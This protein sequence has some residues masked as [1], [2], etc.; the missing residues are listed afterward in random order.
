LRLLVIKTLI[1]A[2]VRGVRLG[3]GLLFAL[4]VDGQEV[5]GD[6]QELAVDDRL[7]IVA[8]RPLHELSQGVEAAHDVVKVIVVQFELI[9]VKQLDDA[10][11][12]VV[13][14]SRIELMKDVV[15]QIQVMP[16]AE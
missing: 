15:L 14:V 3:V 1:I 6:F 13:V 7:L 2:D 5:V 12:Q 8:A 16:F 10:G 9:H 11:N 4:T